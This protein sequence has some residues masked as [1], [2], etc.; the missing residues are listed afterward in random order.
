MITRRR[1]VG[2][3]TMTVSAA[4]LGAAPEKPAEKKVSSDNEQIAAGIQ[5]FIAAYNAGDLQKLMSHYAEDLVK[6][7]QGGATE[8][9]KDTGARTF[10]VFQ[11]FTGEI[12][13]LTEEIVTSGDMAYTRGTFKAILTPR[14]G[15][16]KDQV[17]ERRFLEIWR[18][19]NGE[20]L[21]ART[22]DN[23]IPRAS[24]PIPS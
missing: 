6:S 22:M 4:A 18:K 5:G 19:Q 9:K 20:W 15:G 1:L 21:I 17:I 10:Q 7:R 16:G 8:T 3:A 2:M 24:P 12:S 23:A 13:V 14:Q 11:N